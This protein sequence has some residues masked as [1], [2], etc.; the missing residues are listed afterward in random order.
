MSAE[1]CELEEANRKVQEWKREAKQSVPVHLS[2]GIDISLSPADPQY[3]LPHLSPF[4]VLRT[5]DILTQLVRLPSI[6]CTATVSAAFGALLALLLTA[7]RHPG[8]P[9]SRLEVVR[10]G[11]SRLVRL[12]LCAVASLAYLRYLRQRYPAVL[13]VSQYQNLSHVSD[14]PCFVANRVLTI[15]NSQA[16]THADGPHHFCRSLSHRNYDDAHYSGDAVVLDLSNDLRYPLPNAEVHAITVELMERAC[17]RLPP[18]YRDKSSPLWRLLLVTQP[19]RSSSSQPGE[20][21]LLERSLN[22]LLDNAEVQQMQTSLPTG[23]PLPAGKTNNHNPY[24]FLYPETVEY[25]RRNFPQLLLVGIDTP[26]VDPTDVM[27]LANHCHGALLRCGMAMLEN[28]RFTRLRPLLDTTVSGPK[29]VVVG[30]MLTVFSSTLN[31]DD[32]RGCSVVFFPE[33]VPQ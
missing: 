11:F 28:L 24:A 13:P 25:L 30:S 17:A 7:Q 14:G 10:N 32:A 1:F 20:P 26:S 3:V 29:G 4:Q 21:S 18:A 22:V 16:G 19:P 5:H 6:T 15:T 23:T 33:E 9:L 27:P 2:S 8:G 31:Y 12:L